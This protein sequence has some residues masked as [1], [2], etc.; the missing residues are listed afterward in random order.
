MTETATPAPTA[1]APPPPDP[2]FPFRRLAKRNWDWGLREFAAHLGKAEDDVWVREK[3]LVF[4]KLA[5]AVNNLGEQTL[6]KLLEN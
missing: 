5:E 2:L 6:A 4:R 1:D 3:F